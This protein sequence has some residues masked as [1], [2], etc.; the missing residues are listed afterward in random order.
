MKTASA[1][2]NGANKMQTEVLTPDI[3]RLSSLLLDPLLP[4]PNISSRLQ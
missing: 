2:K 1:R 3:F 4:N